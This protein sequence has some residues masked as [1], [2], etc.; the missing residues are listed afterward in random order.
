[1]C[2]VSNMLANLI[3]LPQSRGAIFFQHLFNFFLNFIEN[4]E[5]KNIFAR[6]FFIQLRNYGYQE[7]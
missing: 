2:L 3:I 4:L 7:A 1:M 6:A 5:M